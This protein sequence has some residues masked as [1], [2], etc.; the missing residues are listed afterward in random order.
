[1]TKQTH[2]RAVMFADLSGSSSLYKVLGNL[3]A[4]QT[5]DDTLSAMIEEVKLHQG[6]L[7]KTIGDEIMV[8][9]E[10]PC[11][12]AECAQMLQRQTTLVNHE[13]PVRIGLCFGDTVVDQDDLFG[14]TVN[15]AAYLTH[16]ARAGQILVS[17]PLA[18]CLS[19]NLRSECHEFDRVVLKGQDHKSLIFRLHWESMTQAHNATRVMSIDE[20]TQ[21]GDA[22]HLHLKFGEQSLDLLPE[23]TPFVLGRDSN[24]ANLRINSSLASR[25][26]CEI[27][28]RR[29]KF[30]LIDHSTNGTYVSTAQQD[31][32]YLRREE[33][34]L[35]GNGEIALGQSVTKADN[36][37]VHFKSN[38]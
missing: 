20:T 7:I 2:A 29:G 33:F 35:V 9:F 12:A 19:E 4:K 8:S 14:E 21:T 15:D 13:L 37:V 18:E 17:Q 24:S 10:D 27:V 32:L 26:H 23:H 5:I 34:P 38:R 22:A 31:E 11:Q 1:M 30:V 6:R 28:F 16:I 36:L 3:D 25:K